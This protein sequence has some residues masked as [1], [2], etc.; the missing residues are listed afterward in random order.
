[1]G[2]TLYD[3]LSPL[4]G[5]A[6]ARHF[7][8]K[9]KIRTKKV[10]HFAPESG[11]HYIPEWVVHFTP[12]YSTK[13]RSRKGAIKCIRPSNPPFLNLDNELS[14]LTNHKHYLL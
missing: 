1:M 2:C 13:F 3:G 10:V 5:A 12:E 9:L 6:T 4:G 8:E 11:V 7:V 14:L